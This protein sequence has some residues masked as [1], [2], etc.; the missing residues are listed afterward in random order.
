MIY[1]AY[2]NNFIITDFPH[3]LVSCTQKM[4]TNL[5]SNITTVSPDL[6]LGVI[7]LT[8]QNRKVVVGDVVAG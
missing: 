7:T 2:I 6:P 5:R 8:L 3:N 1:P 4:P